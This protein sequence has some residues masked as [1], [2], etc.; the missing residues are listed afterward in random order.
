MTAMTATHTRARTRTLRTYAPEKQ[1]F[2]NIERISKTQSKSEN[3]HD[4]AGHGG[5]QLAHARLQPAA[6]QRRGVEA[7]STDLEK[8]DDDDIQ[9]V[10]RYGLRVEGGSHATTRQRARQNTLPRSASKGANAPHDMRHV[11][12]TPLL[13]GFAHKRKRGGISSAKNT[14]E[15]STAATGRGAT[16]TRT[17]SPSPPPPK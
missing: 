7:V 9:G 6:E 15:S 5:Q 2:D 10:C 13:R 3:E 17:N 4:A 12:A 14:C 8:K 11:H 1:E 16:P